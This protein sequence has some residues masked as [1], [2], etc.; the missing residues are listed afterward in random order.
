MVN[1]VTAATAVVDKFTVAAAANQ[2]L[3]SEFVILCAAYE[4]ERLF[5]LVFSPRLSMVLFVFLIFLSVLTH[6]S[7]SSSIMFVVKNSA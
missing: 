2:K 5:S 3:S 4:T 6:L 1:N 7:T